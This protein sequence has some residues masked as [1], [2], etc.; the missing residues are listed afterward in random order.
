[1]IKTVVL[2]PLLAIWRNANLRIAT[3]ALLLLGIGI[4]SINPYQ[5]LVAVQIFGLSDSFYALVLM[6]ASAI[7]VVASIVIGIFTDQKANRRK[8]ALLTSGL[9]AVSLVTIA[10]TGSLFAFV[11]AH[12]VMLPIAGTLFGQI[13]A[14]AR[15]AS[16]DLPTLE[17]DGIMATIR[18]MFAVPF[19]VILPMWSLAFAADIPLMAIYTVAG[20]S[21]CLCL[22]A[23][24][25]KWP[26]DG[27]GH[28]QDAKSGLSFGAS[29]KELA[30]PRVT[31]RL[32]LLAASTSGVALY[33]IL[34]GLI[35]IQQAGRP[36]GDVAI[37]A[38]LIAAL[39]IPF[40][41]LTPLALR[42]TSKS[43]C[44]AGAAIIYAVF[45]ILFGY[46][47]QLPA[48]MPLVLIAGPSAAVLLSQPIA[49]LQD[50]MDN[51]AGAGGALIGLLHF[52]SGIFAAVVFAIGTLFQGYTLT[53]ILGAAT[54]AIAGLLLW[55]IDHRAPNTAP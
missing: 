28:F 53:A 24:I 5:S 40:M 48:V 23:I 39:E 54:V 25:W 19:V 20:L 26:A 9:M 30:A 14:L 3:S 7:S 21:A 50:L 16:A 33:M 47:Q 38:A 45:L 27:A 8:V 55:F 37:F 31:I 2:A 6:S 42:Y 34:L 43:Q 51:R 4:S 13:F 10:F 11:L 22:L 35:L 44:I 29:F 46:S 49:Y 12:A 1:M 17:R 15:L 18:A 41:M 52:M 36:A 32:V